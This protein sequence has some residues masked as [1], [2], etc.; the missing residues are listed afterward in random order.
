MSKRILIVEDSPTQSLLLAEL[1]ESSGFQVTA[2]SDGL[3][4]MEVMAAEELPQLVISDIN[5]PRMD[6]YQLCRAM[7]ADA[8]LEKLPILLLTSLAEEDEVLTGLEA[9]A[10]AFITKPFDHALLL[11]RIGDLIAGPWQQEAANLGPAY[12]LIFSGR[13]Y[14]ISAGRSRILRYLVST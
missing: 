1:L 5:M 12:E 11:E 3:A 6:G 4:A 9:G 10:D 14:S 13:K 7:R 2:A 8:R